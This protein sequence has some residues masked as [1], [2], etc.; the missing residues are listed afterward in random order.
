M[1]PARKCGHV[2]AGR[3]F[4]AHSEHKDFGKLSEGMVSELS[5]ASASGRVQDA[6]RSLMYVVWLTSVDR[7]L[8]DS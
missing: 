6:Y 3:C 1:R 8:M 4:N 5:A 7:E 2:L